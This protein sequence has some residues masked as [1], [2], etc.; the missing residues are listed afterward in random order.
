VSG[1]DSYAETYADSRRWLREGWLDYIAP[2][3]YWQL[4]GEEHRFTKL[5]A[6][7]RS[8]NVAHR[9]VWPGLFTMRVESRGDPWPASEIPAEI[10]WLRQASDSDGESSGHIHF[11]LGAMAPDGALGQRLER[12]TYAVP[13]LPPA[14]PWLG[15]ATP[16][17]PAVDGCVADVAT[18]ADSALTVQVPMRVRKDGPAVRDA[19]GAMQPTPR[20]LTSGPALRV[21]ADGSTPVRWWVLQLRDG[22]GRWHEQT[23]AGDLK[24]LPL[25]LPNDE[26]ATAAAVTPVS[27]SG[28]LGPATVVRLE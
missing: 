9:H 26:R 10:A 15:S 22:A 24:M 2:Q 18:A 17:A 8:Q 3:L 19:T 21:R 23:L 16:G 13:A 11:R 6:W 1:L 12:D 7:W 20:A 25:S 4:D 5:D 28:V 27:P 14:S